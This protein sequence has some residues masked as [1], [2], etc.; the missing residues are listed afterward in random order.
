MAI[1]KLKTKFVT[2]AFVNDVKHFFKKIN[3]IIDHLNNSNNGVSYNS[4]T[5]LISQ[6]GTANPTVEILE[7]T[8]LIDPTLITRD[9]AGDYYIN[10]SY[11]YTDS[12]IGIFIGNNGAGGSNGRFLGALYNGGYVYIASRDSSNTPSDNL[13]NNVLVEIRVYN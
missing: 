7:N 13:L 6:S 2:G 11:S 5:F 3:E 10:Q 1:E 12:Q 9:S 4:C 8:T